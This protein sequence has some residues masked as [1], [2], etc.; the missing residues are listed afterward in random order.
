M[1]LKTATSDH[2]KLVAALRKAIER[3]KYFFV[4]AKADPIFRPARAH[5]DALLAEMLSD[6]KEKAE[7]A[8]ASAQQSLDVMEDWH[9]DEDLTNYHMAQI[10]MRTLHNLDT[11]SYL[12]S[13][14]AAS[15]APSASAYAADAVA[16]KVSALSSRLGRLTER[17]HSLR[18]LEWPPVGGEPHDWR[19]ERDAAYEHCERAIRLASVPGYEVYRQAESLL[20]RGVGRLDELK[21]LAEAAKRKAE[22]QAD[23][24]K[25]QADEAKLKAER[26]AD[27]AKRKAERQADEA[28]RKADEA[29]RKAE[30][31]AAAAERK[32]RR[33]REKRTELI[34]L[35]LALGL[36]LL[37]VALA[38][39]LFSVFFAEPASGPLM[40]LVGF[41]LSPIPLSIADSIWNLGEK[42][43]ATEGSVGYLWLLLLGPVA[44]F[45]SLGWIFATYTQSLKAISVRYSDI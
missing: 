28:K 19:H 38:G 25:R 7:Y 2:E 44:G 17:Y 6:A 35:H 10:I 8:I 41:F 29:K 45:V 30:R 40:Y 13:L 21:T 33:Q 15:L 11:Q 4:A 23:E 1:R 32:A 14:D 5:V 31:Q 43:P 34:K 37:S 9:A 20:K 3:N 18:G 24:A 22:R 12:Q 39:V 16:A 36:L 42:K 26:Q 27:E